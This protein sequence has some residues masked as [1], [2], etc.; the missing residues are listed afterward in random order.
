ML[1]AAVFLAAFSCPSIGQGQEQGHLAQVTTGNSLYY[2]RHTDPDC[3]EP[4]FATKHL[5]Y[6]VDGSQNVPITLNTCLNAADKNF[7]VTCKFG[8]SKYS[9]YET[10]YAD[11]NCRTPL[12]QPATQSV[13]TVFEHERLCQR[14]PELDTYQRIHCGEDAKAAM[15]YPTLVSPKLFPNNH[16][17][18]S[19][20]SSS[21]KRQQVLLDRCLPFYRGRVIEAYL[22][23]SQNKWSPTGGLELTVKTFAK[24]DLNCSQ[25]TA[26]L[27]SVV[28][29]P[30]PQLGGGSPPC[31][32]DPLFT[33][34]HYLN[35]PG[36]A[37]FVQLP[38]PSSAPTTAPTSAPPTTAPTPAPTY[39]PTPAPS[40]LGSIIS[41]DFFL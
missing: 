28:Y 18:S 16:C 12:Q 15:V 41:A 17:G 37:P 30:V 38:P 31:V 21:T 32:K 14:D 10:R 7:M 4:Y 6:T 22:I 1:K 35:A 26:N 25:P 33:D 13:M 36:Q 29:P 24:S 39:N 20:T 5:K 23:L 2:T 3:I 40:P 8:T 27:R 9:L 19:S 34:F 11:S